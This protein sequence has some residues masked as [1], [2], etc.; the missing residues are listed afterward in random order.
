MCIIL[1]IP[2]A[3]ENVNDI[4]VYVLEKIISYARDNQDIFIAQ[5]V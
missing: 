3:I 4:I 1:Q 2:I 5:C